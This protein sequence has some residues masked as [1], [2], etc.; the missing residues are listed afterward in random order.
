MVDK[1]S[2]YPVAYR[3]QNFALVQYWWLATVGS[4]LDQSQILTLGLLRR[5]TTLD[6][7]LIQT[8]LPFEGRQ[9]NLG[10][11][12]GISFSLFQSMVSGPSGE[13]GGNVP[14]PVG[15]VIDPEGDDVTTQPPTTGVRTASGIR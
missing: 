12:L 11:R 1:T 6:Q 14:D 13:S 4:L 5:K 8:T 15:K 3:W 10:I 2:F 9:A 7:P